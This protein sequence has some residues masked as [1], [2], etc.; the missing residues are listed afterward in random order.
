MLL[1]VG[2]GNPGDEYANTPHNLGFKVVDRLAEEA[3]ISVRRPECR[4]LVGRGRLEGREVTLAK[5]MCYMNNSG[6]VV[7]ALLERYELGTAGLL[8]VFDDL[9]LPWT[10]IRVRER[11]SAGGHHGM[12]SIIEALGSREFARLR[13]GVGGLHQG[14]GA[15]DFL[16]SPFRRAQRKDVEDLVG[17]GAEAVRS[18]IAEGAAQAMTRWNRRAPGQTNEEQ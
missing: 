9:N 8:V 3:A 17:R 11:G 2:L 6:P 18:I 13:L 5:P 15:T 12:E 7:R 4:S 16:L 14:P 10:S 1:I